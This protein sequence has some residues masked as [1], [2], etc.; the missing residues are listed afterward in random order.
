M[1]EFTSWMFDT[2]AAA[3]SL[4]IGGVLESNPDLVVLHPHAGGTLPFISGR[5]DFL[6]ASMGTGMPKPT[7]EYL[8]SR[9]YVDTV[10][11]TPGA[12]EM[13]AST[14]GEDRI[15]FASDYPWIP[16][17]VALQHVR[18]HL[19]DALTHRVLEINTIPGLVPSKA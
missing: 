11:T 6:D 8:R 2:S 14:Y 17:A 4:V 13:A 12:L 7:R 10:T 19:T 16:R 15:V 3:L 1:L 9:F 18:E 5:I